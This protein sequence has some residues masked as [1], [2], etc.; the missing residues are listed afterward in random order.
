V[1]ILE[2]GEKTVFLTLVE[3]PVV[4]EQLRDLQQLVQQGQVCLFTFEIFGH[5]VVE[6]LL[7]VLVVFVE[8]LDD[9]DDRF[10]DDV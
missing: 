6:H 10:E 2:C 5:K 9:V 7:V 8:D 3:H 4:L 1:Y